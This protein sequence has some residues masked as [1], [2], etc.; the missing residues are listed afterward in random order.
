MVGKCSS[1]QEDRNFHRAKSCSDMRLRGIQVQ[2][3]ICNEKSVI[4]CCNVFVALEGMVC[5]LHIPTGCFFEMLYHDEGS[6]KKGVFDV[7]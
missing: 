3:N 4:F 5:N 2:N 6:L 1:I 7:R